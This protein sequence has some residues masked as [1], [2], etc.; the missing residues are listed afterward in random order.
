MGGTSIPKIDLAVEYQGEQHFKPIEIFGGEKG[1][2]ENK[3]RDK[4]KKMLCE[5]NG[6]RLEYINYDQ[7]MLERI[8]EIY[9]KYYPTK[10]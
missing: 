8:K 3:E 9:I 5:A 4:R 2:Q 7:D 10:S 6:I 1:F